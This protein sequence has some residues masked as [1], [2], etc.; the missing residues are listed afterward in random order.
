M[1]LEI[2]VGGDTF[3]IEGE[4]EI[5]EEINGLVRTF[6]AASDTDRVDDPDLLL[7]ATKKTLAHELTEI[8]A[9]KT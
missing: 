4:F 1:K 5:T 3:K 2:N 6:L 7:A 9:K 8:A